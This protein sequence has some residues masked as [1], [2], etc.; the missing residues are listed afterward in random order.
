M[1][2]A[3]K[4][5]NRVFLWTVGR[6]LSTVF[7]KCLSFVD[8][9]QII[10]EPFNVAHTC[11]PERLQDDGSRIQAK[12]EA[13]LNTVLSA[14]S[15]SSTGYDVNLS[16]YDWVK[17][18]LEADYPGKQIVFCKDFAFALRENYD[19]IPQGYRHTFLIRDP[20]KMFPSFKKGW[21]KLFQ[22]SSLKYQELP[23]QLNPPKHA[24]GELYE[25]Y[26]YVQDYG[27]E[28][29]PIIIDADDLQRDPGSILPQYCKAVGIPYSENLLQWEA[30]AKVIDSWKIASIFM[31]GN[32]M[33]EDE[34]YDAAFSSTHFLPPGDPPSQ[35]QIDEDLLPLID[36][37]MGYYDN[38]YAA[39]IKP[40]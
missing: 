26:Q 15:S 6:S 29:D 13:T 38:M 27:L 8:G 3:S 4:T 10:N 14:V 11:G 39:R 1:A 17:K 35:D 20:W 16:T 2:D 18:M 5:T 32:K 37:S 24:F 25:L 40:E 31:E 33:E 9:I 7:T 34:F 28:K 23:A 12:F 36:K 21:V 30:G 22:D 19:W